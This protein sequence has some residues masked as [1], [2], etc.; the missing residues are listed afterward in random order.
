MTSPAVTLSAACMPGQ[1]LDAP[2][3]VGGL[4]LQSRLV[5]GTGKYARYAE[6]ARCLAASGTDCVT[7][8]VRRERLVNAAG[9][10][11]LDHQYVDAHNPNTLNVGR[12][13]FLELSCKF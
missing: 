10:N 3:H 7:V 8:A 5:V 12:M 1:V 2:L 4:T 11:L 6:M 13:L 9:E